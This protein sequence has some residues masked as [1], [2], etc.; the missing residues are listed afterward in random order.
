MTSTDTFSNYAKTFPAQLY[1]KTE[2]E[3]LF[4]VNFLPAVNFLQK[5]TNFV[6]HQG[7]P[8]LYYAWFQLKS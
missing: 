7:N 8:K 1:W 4:A 5:Q 6:F 3:K 2:N